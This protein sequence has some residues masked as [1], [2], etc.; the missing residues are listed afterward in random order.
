MTRP[1][2]P[3]ESIAA[4]IAKRGQPRR[5]HHDLSDEHAALVASIREA[6][7][8]GR[9][10]TKKNTAAR[11]ISA[12]LKAAGIADIGAQGITEWLDRA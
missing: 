6:W 3:I 7:L 4:A 1:A 8:S 12:Y 5:W 11:E 10:G 9:L 2:G